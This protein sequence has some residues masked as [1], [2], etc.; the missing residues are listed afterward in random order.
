MDRRQKRRK[1]FKKK[2]RREMDKALIKKR[3]N[4]HN[5]GRLKQVEGKFLK[6]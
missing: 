1:K 4:I 3:K 5:Y 6:G 2:W